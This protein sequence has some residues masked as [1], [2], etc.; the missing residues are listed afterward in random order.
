MPSD[1][2]RLRVQR[3]V[4][5]KIY[6]VTIQE[7]TP[8]LQGNGST[9]V[10]AKPTPP[11]DAEYVPV[12]IQRPCAPSEEKCLIETYNLT[13]RRIK[14][15]LAKAIKKRRAEL[16]LLA[17]TKA[18]ADKVREKQTAF[19]K[20]VKKK[21][22]SCGRVTLMEE[23]QELG[24]IQGYEIV[25]KHIP[26]QTIH[27]TADTSTIISERT[28]MVMELPKNLESG[29]TYLES[30]LKQHSERI[31]TIPT[32]RT[33][34]YL[35]AYEIVKGKN[36]CKKIVSP[37]H[38]SK[39]SVGYLSDVEQLLG[40]IEEDFYNKRPPAKIQSA[41]CRCGACA[42]KPPVWKVGLKGYWSAAEED[43]T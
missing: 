42:N 43:V 39:Q 36:G 14:N 30:F 24:P 38:L 35:P 29:P 9:K 15:R 6:H 3:R 37:K 10:T 4:G 32:T 8:K 41:S 25:K 34:E 11:Q 17:T 2:S 31:S 12:L 27:H 19:E 20:N 33:C 22:N 16:S 7:A 5:G 26:E 23:K 40:Y 18:A 28:I 1:I 21:D 13:P